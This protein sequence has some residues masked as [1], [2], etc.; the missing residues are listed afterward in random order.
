MII[1]VSFFNL[2]VWCITDW[3]ADI[4]KSLHPLDK[5]HLIMVVKVK[6]L[7]RVWLCDPMDC[8]LLGSSVHGI[9]QARALEWVAISFS[10]GSSQPRGWTRVSPHCSL[11]LYRL[12][13][14]GSI[15]IMVYEPFNVLL[16]MFCWGF[17]HLCSHQWYWPVIVFLFGAFPISCIC[18]LLTIADF[19]TIFVCRWFPTFTVCLSLPVSFPIRNFVSS[20][21][22]FFST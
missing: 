14:Q 4:E 18:A 16:L 19:D 2:W 13:H 12:S 5:P 1:W 7:S 3:F 10:R 15:V 9:F 6:S 20:H 22:L 21:G 11:A 17:L 8:S